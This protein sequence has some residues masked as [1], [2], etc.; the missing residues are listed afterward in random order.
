MKPAI[1]A[2]IVVAVI[3]VGFIASNTFLK[4]SMSAADYKAQITQIAAEVN[5][6]QF[7]D[8]NTAISGDQASRDAAKAAYDKV[9]SMVRADFAK[10]RAM[11]PPAEFQS[12]HDR[13]LKGMDAEDKVLTAMDVVYRDLVSG[14]LTE[15]NAQDY[16]ALVAVTNLTNDPA[17]TAAVTDADAAVTEIQAK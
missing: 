7:G 11:K 15:A 10:A 13:I 3:A 14:A 8:L 9:A 6:A 16:P 2:A 4:P 1:I 17:I 12:Q 5:G